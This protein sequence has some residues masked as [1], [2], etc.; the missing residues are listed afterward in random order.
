M[1][2]V[3]LMNV[4]L[5]GV[6]LA[7]VWVARAEAAKVFLEAEEFVVQKGDWQAKDWG[8][9]YY[10]S[11][12]A[13]SFLSR[14]KYLGAPEQGEESVAVRDFDVPADGTYRVLIRYEACWR[15]QTIFGAR[16]EQGGK[17]V[18]QRD[19]GALDNVKVW[20]FG[21]GLKKEVRWWWGPDENIVWEG[22]DYEVKLAKGPAR[23]ILTK[24]RQPEPAA[25]RNVDI[26]MLTDEVED[27]DKRLKSENYLPFDGLLTQDGDLFIRFRNVGSVGAFQASG[28]VT[29]HSSYWVHMRAWPGIQLERAGTVEPGGMSEWLEI[30]SSLDSLNENTLGLTLKATEEGVEE[31][32]II[33]FAVPENG[34]KKVI[35]TIQCEFAG[36]M[37]MRIAVPG[38]VRF[39]KPI[40]TSDEVTQAIHDYCAALP[41]KGKVPTLTPI[42]GIGPCNGIGSYYIAVDKLPTAPIESLGDE[43]GLPGVSPE[44]A[45]TQQRFRDYAKKMR[46]APEDLLEEAP[47]GAAKEELWGRVMLNLDD[48]KRPVSYYHSQEFRIEEGIRQLKERTAGRPYVGANYSPHVYYWPDEGKWV[49]VFKRLG[50]TMPWGEDYDWQIP[51]L[52]VQITSY[53]IDVF[54]C[55]AKYHNLPIMFYVMPHA[56]G[57][58]ARDFR[59]SYYQAF[60]HGTKLVNFFMAEPIV[61]GYTE[62]YV[63]H[64]ALD[65]WKALH[66][67]VY[68]TGAWED[69]I[70]SGHVRPAKVA[71]VLSSVSDIWD[72]SPAYN[73]ERKCLYFALRHS[74][75]PVDFLTEEDMAEGYLK[76]Y[77]VVYLTSE[78]LH[79][80][81]AAALAR[82]V[83]SGGVLFSVAGGGFKNEY[84]Q[85]NRLMNRLYGI[86]EQSLERHADIVM[87]KADLPWMEPLDTVAISA[88]VI[89][90]KRASMPALGFKQTLKV[91]TAQVYGTFRDGSPA[92]TVNSYGK[93]R[94]MLVATWPGA[95]YVKPAIPLRPCDRGDT[96]DAMDH[97]LPTNYDVRA[98]CLIDLPTLWAGV[99]P[100]VVTWEPLVCSTIIDAPGG[101]AIPLMNFSGSPIP[102]LRVI[103]KVEG[104]FS[105]I[106]TVEQGEVTPIRDG[107]RLIFKLPMGTTDMI[108]LRR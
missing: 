93:G 61:N 50:M 9:N 59:L 100:D 28:G 99:E 19:Y 46:V 94:A 92:I 35:K 104:E 90:Q 55:G 29:E 71:L 42:F 27:L 20:A 86:A 106:S 75:L 49:R 73:H 63:R 16:I 82:W 2:R 78:Y 103:V 77:K 87:T 53:L 56:P 88:N 10:C 85:P 81:A 64:E 37:N 69:L 62:N 12:F 107:D 52:S 67:V 33:E 72:R 6:A 97:F 41:K 11:T 96:D 15:F 47:P 65:H 70:Q 105:S 4:A 51:E 25:R 24:G 79:S 95:A 3:R 40:L 58:T 48:P 83:R 43:I 91:S 34:T 13:N 36:S 23:M 31:E 26:V 39:G 74:N 84:N 68:E 60:A 1:V 76:D 80:R 7:G 54:R 32:A 21:E 44:N 101:I 108:M 66:D 17:T 30:G 102:S 38:G 98:K 22:Y 57:N 18:F 45:E 8:T 5:L 14:Q 89:G